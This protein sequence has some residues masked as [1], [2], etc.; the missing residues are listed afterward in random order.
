[1][2]QLLPTGRFKWVDVNPHEIRKLTKHED[3]GYLLEVD[4]SYPRDL[5]DSHNNLPFMCE[6]MD[7][8]GIEKLVPNL[9]DKKGYIIH[10]Q[11]LD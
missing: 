9:R 11:A 1:M 6:C 2:S 5:H 7:I 8:N 4:I 3:K 10:I